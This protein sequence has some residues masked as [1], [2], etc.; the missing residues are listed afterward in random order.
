MQK[1]LGY[2]RR[3]LFLAIA[4]AGSYVE[5]ASARSPN[6]LPSCT[7]TVYDAVAGQNT[8]PDGA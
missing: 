5:V 6:G 1:G 2:I 3:K 4:T 7:V 8:V